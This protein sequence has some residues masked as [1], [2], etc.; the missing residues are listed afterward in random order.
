MIAFLTGLA[1]VAGLAQ[2][3]TGFGFALLFTP[4]ATATLPPRPAISSALVVGGVAA[5]AV[6][7]R[8]RRSIT[9]GRSAPLLVGGALGSLAGTRLVYLVDVHVARIA[10]A[11]VAAGSA[12]L[13]WIARPKPARN[14]RATFAMAGALGGVLN[15]STSMGGPPAAL[16]LAGQRWEPD[17]SRATMAAFNAL[18]FGFA[19]TT[20]AAF[21]GLG[22]VSWTVL[23]WTVPAALVGTFAGVRLSRRLEQRAFDRVVLLTIMV[24]AAVAVVVAVT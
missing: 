16:A 24:A 12:L 21:G 2:G 10:V 22:G 8:C 1:V 5:L 13:F 15:A 7:V 17:P 19:L 9:L 20:A 4:L 18:C 11:V 23:G 3:A 14:E 6:L